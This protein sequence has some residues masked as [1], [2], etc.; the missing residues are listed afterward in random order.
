MRASVAGGTATSRASVKVECKPG[1]FK[2]LVKSKPLSPLPVASAQS[3]NCSIL[4]CSSP[5]KSGI[6]DKNNEIP[7]TAVP[8]C[9]EETN[10]KF[11][12]SAAP[13]HRQSQQSLNKGS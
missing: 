11:N 3:P 5:Q 10:E 4:E 6:L 1:N 7:M 13:T 2:S 12:S 9:P 8:E